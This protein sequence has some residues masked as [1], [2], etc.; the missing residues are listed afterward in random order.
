MN[1][2]ARSQLAVLCGLLLCSQPQVHAGLIHA[3]AQAETTLAPNDSSSG[4]AA[5]AIASAGLSNGYGAGSAYSRVGTYGIV[6]RLIQ[7]DVFAM[8][9]DNYRFT[10]WRSRAL[11]SWSDNI[12]GNGAGPAPTTLRLWVKVHGII[13][14]SE[15]GIFTADGGNAGASSSVRVTQ[16]VDILRGEMSGYWGFTGR[17]PNGLFGVTFSGVNTSMEKTA[18]GWEFSGLKSFELSKD[19]YSDKYDFKVGMISEA[20][21]NEGTIR[22]NLLN[23]LGLTDVT[24]SDGTSVL[25]DISLESELTFASTNAVPE[26]TTATIFGAG[27]LAC[28]CFQRRRKATRSVK[29]MC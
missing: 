7:Q 21:A 10:S 26:P 19:A 13:P 5:T 9:S 3:S 29:A 28:T 14:D 16:G 15:V 12:Y 25:S 1:C 4:I 2:F 27:L 23:T 18:V 17:G 20:G 24:L 8:D 22:L 11:G 6:E